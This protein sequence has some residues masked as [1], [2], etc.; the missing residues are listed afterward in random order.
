MGLVI[1]VIVYM[2]PLHC[3]E[4]NKL[5]IWLGAYFRLWIKIRQLLQKQLALH[6]RARATKPSLPGNL[7]RSYFQRFRHISEVTKLT[8]PSRTML[9]NYVHPRKND[10]RRR[11]KLYLAIIKIP[12]AVLSDLE[13]INGIE[14]E[15]S[16]P[17][18]SALS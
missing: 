1:T 4:V 8:S 14:S 17:H 6:T 11:Y 12:Y 2:W 7:F 5:A 16:M 9:D 18:S 10:I 15:D 3:I 13:L